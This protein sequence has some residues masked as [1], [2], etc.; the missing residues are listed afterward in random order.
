MTSDT[1]SSA[2][3]LWHFLHVKMRGGFGGHVSW[4]AQYLMNLNDVLKGLKV[5]ESLVL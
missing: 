1:F 2:W 3:Q 5:F 4:Q